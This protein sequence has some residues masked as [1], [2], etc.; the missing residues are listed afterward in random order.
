M[1]LRIILIQLSLIISLISFSQNGIIEREG[2]TCL[3]ETDLE[4]TSLNDSLNC[5]IAISKESPDK[6][7]YWNGNSFQENLFGGSDGTTTSAVY[8]AA[9]NEIDF[10]NSTGNFSYNAIPQNDTA[11]TSF[12]IRSSDLAIEGRKYYDSDIGQPVYFDKFNKPVRYG[13][14]DG[15]CIVRYNAT[16]QQWEVL[17]DSGHT[18]SETFVSV[19]SNADPVHNFKINVDNP[20]GSTR[21]EIGTVLISPDETASAYGLLAGA[22]V[23]FDAINVK[24]YDNNGFSLRINN[25]QSPSVVSS[26]VLMPTTT[27]AYDSAT[28]RLTVNHPNMIV[29][30]GT[31]INEND[32]APMVIPATNAN[33]T[34][35]KFLANGVGKN[36]ATFEFYDGAIKQLNPTGQFHYFRNFSYKFEE[37]NA[38][39]QNVGS[40]M[41]FWVFWRFLD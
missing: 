11:R 4:I 31:G 28:S 6:R 1:T 30:G 33:W 22:S 13:Y 3:F 37:S 14:W 18:P 35:A 7:F 23:G 10:S 20:T 39:S 8:D 27:F 19:I 15:H 25:P 5:Q 32:Y 34:S 26:S 9:N 29:G 40:S 12:N 2:L 36:F 21:R 38:N 24:V 41:N 16:S 17:E